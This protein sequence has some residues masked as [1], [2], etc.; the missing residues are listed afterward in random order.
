MT[1]PDLVLTILLG[2]GLGLGSYSHVWCITTCDAVQL[3]ITCTMPMSS[4]NSLSDWGLLFF[5]SLFNCSLPGV[6]HFLLPA[7]CGLH[8]L[9]FFNGSACINMSSKC[10]SAFFTCSCK[11][12]SI[13]IGVLHMCRV[14]SVINLP[15]F[16]T[17]IIY[18]HPLFH[19][20]K[21]LCLPTVLLL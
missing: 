17:W 12:C 20:S 6:I 2:L 5:P 8:V 16:V 4:L 13:V 18:D 7:V 1:H 19:A 15:V 14:F 3:L 10:Q 21:A 9:I 11:Y